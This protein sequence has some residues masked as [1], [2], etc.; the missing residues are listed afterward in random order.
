MGHISNQLLLLFPN[1]NQEQGGTAGGEAAAQAQD[2]AQMV[3]AT[4]EEV[5]DESEQQPQHD[6]LDDPVDIAEVT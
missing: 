1:A 4:V 6:L 5:V 2:Q 3:Q